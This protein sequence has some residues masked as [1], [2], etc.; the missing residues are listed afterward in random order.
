MPKFSALLILVLMAQA[1][2]KN[3]RL[4]G[5]DEDLQVVIFAINLIKSVHIS[6]FSDSR[7]FFDSNVYQNDPIPEQSVEVLLSCC[8]MDQMKCFYRYGVLYLR[9]FI[10]FVS[11]P[12]MGRNFNIYT[13]ICVF[14]SLVNPVLHI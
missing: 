11:S 1:S 14:I 3:Q 12:S 8:K 13:I 6:L 10:H 7:T 4:S 9:Y 5:L 2:V